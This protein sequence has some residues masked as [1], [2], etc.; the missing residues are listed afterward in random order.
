MAN[1]EHLDLLKQGGTA[2]NE[3]REAHRSVEPDLSRA[4]LGEVHC[5]YT[6]FADIDL[7]TVKAVSSSIRA[8][9][10]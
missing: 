5:A 2:W 7:Q 3:W 1:Q 8:S 6:I 4:D 9:F 10:A